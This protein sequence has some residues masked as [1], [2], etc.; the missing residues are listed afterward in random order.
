ML[1]AL[2][3]AALVAL[4]AVVGAAAVIAVEYFE[5]KKQEAVEETKN[6]NELDAINILASERVAYYTKVLAIFTGALSVFGLLQ[7]FFLIRADETARV[8]ANAARDAAEAAK[9]QSI[10]MNKAANLAERQMALIGLQTD[11]LEK[12][13]EIAR[14]E[15]L[16]THRPRI[17]LREAIIGTVVEGQPI[18]VFFSLANVGELRGKI[19]RSWIRVE[20]VNEQTERLFLVQSVEPHDDIGTIFLDGGEQRMLRP[21]ESQTMP[22]WKANAFQRRPDFPEARLNTIHLA[23]Q[24]LYTDDLNVQRRTVFRRVLVPEKQRF[25]RIASEPDLDYSD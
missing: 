10:E 23:G 21:P 16:S 2:K 25:Y 24:I 3:L 9:A 20:V 19:I 22:I 6:K 11:I 7:I 12:Q 14:H 1:K 13:K 8:S 18:N 15:F 17:I 4:I 5:P